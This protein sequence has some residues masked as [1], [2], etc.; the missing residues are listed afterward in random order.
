MPYTTISSLSDSAPLTHTHLNTLQ[1]NAEFLYDIVHVMNWPFASL[2]RNSTGGFG[3]G[4]S[5]WTI[6]HRMRYL[7]FQVVAGIGSS[8][9]YIRVFYNGR[10]VW[11]H[12][13]P[14]LTTTSY[15]D[16][17]DISSWPNYRGAWASGVNYDNSNAG[18]GDLVS[19]SGV[20]Y[21]CISDHISGS[22]TQ[23]GIGASW[24]TR[25]VVQDLPVLGGLY[26]VYIDID[27]AGDE[28]EL[29]VDYIF[30]DWTVDF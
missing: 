16:L 23:P 21:R 3:F 28:N 19:Q 11:G 4:N 5:T 24:E 29:A 25:W 17:Y 6:R 18:D 2:H 27:F 20:Y 8:L 9:E 1:A 14:S 22:T 7:K 15:A 10:K 30:E 26:N 13:T 12:E